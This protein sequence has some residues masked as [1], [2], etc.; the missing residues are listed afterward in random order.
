M[1]YV[2]MVNSRLRSESDGL[3]RGRLEGYSTLGGFPLLH[4]FHVRMYALH[5]T[6]VKLGVAE[7]EYPLPTREVRRLFPSANLPDTCG[8]GGVPGL[9]LEQGY[10]KSWERVMDVV[11]EAPDVI[12][13]SV[14]SR[15]D[16]HQ[17]QDPSTLETG[18]GYLSCKDTAY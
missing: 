8:H 18:W 14:D 2:K 12:I 1:V 3:P 5:F 4:N 6:R 9:L 16:W 7:Q 13:H 17:A 10:V 11:E 15:T